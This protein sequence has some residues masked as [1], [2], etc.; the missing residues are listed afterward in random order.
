MKKCFFLILLFFFNISKEQINKEIWKKKSEELISQIQSLL[1]LIKLTNYD[2]Y[3]KYSEYFDLIDDGLNKIKYLDTI[4]KQIEELQKII[5]NFSSKIKDIIPEEQNNYINQLLNLFNQIV[6]N[7]SSNKEFI[8]KFITGNNQFIDEQKKKLDNGYIKREKANYDPDKILNIKN[9]DV[10]MFILVLSISILLILIGK[11]MIQKVKLI[12]IVEQ[13]NNKEIIVKKYN[14][15]Q[16]SLNEP[17][18]DKLYEMN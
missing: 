9:I 13:I 10:I 16:K 18:I 14:K 17:L 7:F 2:I 3:S 11:R 1:L 5:I 12:N 4:E 6:N 8:E 15:N